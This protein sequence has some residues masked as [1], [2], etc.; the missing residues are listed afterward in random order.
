MQQQCVFL[1]L[2]TKK[3]R[4]YLYCQKAGKEISF[5][6]CKCCAFKEYKR[7]TYHD[8]C[9]NQYSIMPPL[10]IT[11]LQDDRQIICFNKK[12]KYYHKHHVF[13]GT[14][15]RLLSDKYGLFVWIDPLTHADFHNNIKLRKLLENEGRKAFEEHYPTLNFTEIFGKTYEVGNE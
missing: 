9:K 5:S 2:K 15:K 7:K 11:S 3:K 12:C 14:G 8:K 13:A 6:C 10:V 4:R 1:K